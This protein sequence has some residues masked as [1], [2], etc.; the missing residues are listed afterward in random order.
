[1]Q[2]ARILIVEDEALLALELKSELEE[3]SYVIVGI[4]GN[5]AQATKL[6]LEEEPDI[7][8]MDIMLHD[9]DNGIE[10]AA[11]LKQLRDVP[12]VFMSAY[13][14]PEVIEQAKA[15][16]PFA[17]LPKPLNQTLL[18]IQIEMALNLHSA[19]HAPAVKANQ[20][21]SKAFISYSHGE[22]DQAFVEELLTHLKPLRRRGVKIW[23]DH[24]IAAG[25]KW[26]E[27]IE[28]ALDDS[29]V[30]ILL[31]SPDFL[32]SD[33]IT[34]EELPKLLA[35]A[36]NE[37]TR[38]LSV[39]LRPCH[40]PDNLR[41]FKTVNDPNRTLAELNLPERDRVWMLLVDLIDELVKRR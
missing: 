31:V 14:N 20:S 41:S 3:F 25:D 17:Y 2:R 10:I 38:I 40:I 22:L 12:F 7:V 29:C 34:N 6:F 28:K 1:M 39:L 18:R 27:E 21:N 26:H 4:A 5:E 32:A 8:L 37:G 35:Q 9:D 19:M 15:V 30:G 36:N 16:H 13:T 11:K 23:S 33:F 24:E